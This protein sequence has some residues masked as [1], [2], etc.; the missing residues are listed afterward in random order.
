MLGGLFG[1]D[2][3]ADEQVKEVGLFKGLVYCYIPKLR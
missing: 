2:D 3:G 1:G